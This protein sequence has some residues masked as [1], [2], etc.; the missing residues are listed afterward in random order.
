MTI[1]DQE[2]YWDVLAPLL[3]VAGPPPFPNPFFLFVNTLTAVAV[4][5]FSW[6]VSCGSAY[7]SLFIVFGS[8][9]MNL[10]SHKTQK[11]GREVASTQ[12]G[13]KSEEEGG[14]RQVLT[15]PRWA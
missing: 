10:T 3:C 2:Q 11:M 14:I 6:D 13:H 9:G 12:A 7:T 4:V 1:H 15:H 5:C 8:G